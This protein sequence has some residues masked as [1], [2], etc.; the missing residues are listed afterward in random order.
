MCCTDDALRSLNRVLTLNTGF[1]VDTIC[2]KRE[3]SSGSQC[4]A[5]LRVDSDQGIKSFPFHF[6]VYRQEGRERIL[7]F[8]YMG[9]DNRLR[10]WDVEE[11][12]ELKRH[13]G[14]GFEAEEVRRRHPPLFA[15]A[16]REGFW[17]DR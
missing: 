17:S 9:P 4:K 13:G 1:A 2:Q 12:R 8:L 7:Y 16:Q 5:H 6:D 3:F 15:L 10:L 14:K 11:G